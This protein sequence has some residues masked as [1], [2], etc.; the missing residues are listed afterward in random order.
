MAT[1]NLKFS[2]HANGRMRQRGLRESDISFIFQHGSQIDDAVFFLSNK[3]TDREIRRRKREIQTLG[4]LR[5]K[6][7][8]TA[9]ANI[10]N[11][12]H[13]NNSDQKRILR[14]EREYA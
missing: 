6:K 10:V 7:V 2:N 3:D 13:S 1:S 5:N 12:Y 14:K 11:C 8:V 4:R 9:G